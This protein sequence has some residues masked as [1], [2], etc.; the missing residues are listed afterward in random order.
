MREREGRCERRDGGEEEG[1]DGRKGVEKKE[2]GERGTER[3]RMRGKRE[4]R[5]DKEENKRETG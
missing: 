4:K 3:G 1:V 2:M 5:R